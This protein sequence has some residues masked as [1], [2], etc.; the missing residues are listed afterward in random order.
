MT[1]GNG[2]RVCYAVDL[3]DNLEV[4]ER[5]K[6]LHMPGAPPIAVTAALRD[7]GISSLQIYLIGNRLFM[8]MEVNTNYD[9]NLKSQRDARNPEVQ[10]WNAMMETLQQ[11]LPFSTREAA[12]GKWRRMQR[13]YD[14]SSQ[15]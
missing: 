12:A 15:P 7:A 9:A 11:E 3:E 6:A 13:I 2:N 14:L 1:P 4:I 8:I 10:A 5:Y